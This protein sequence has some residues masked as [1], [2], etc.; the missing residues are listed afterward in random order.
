MAQSQELKELK[1]D[2]KLTG[3][4]EVEAK[5]ILGTNTCQ[6]LLPCRYDGKTVTVAVYE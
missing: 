3:V 5:K 6:L 1:P 4:F 2:M